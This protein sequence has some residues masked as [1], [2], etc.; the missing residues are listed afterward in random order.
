MKNKVIV[1]KCLKIIPND[2][3]KSQRKIAFQKLYKLSKKKV[4]YFIFSFKLE[5]NYFFLNKKGI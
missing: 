5:I 3:N 2:F 4:F 1:E